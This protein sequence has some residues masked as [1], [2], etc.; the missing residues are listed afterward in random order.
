MHFL[1]VEEFLCVIKCILMMLFVMYW[2][3]PSKLFSILQ[4]VSCIIKSSIL[5][6]YLGLKHILASHKML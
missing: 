1:G 5:N 3:F 4:Y 6:I 2:A